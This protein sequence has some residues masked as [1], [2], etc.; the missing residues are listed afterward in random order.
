MP[1]FDYKMHGK[2]FTQNY[3]EMNL[4]VSLVLAFCS[5]R[6]YVIRLMSMFLFNLSKMINI[7]SYLTWKFYLSTV[8]LKNYPMSVQFPTAQFSTVK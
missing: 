4:I 2:N 7:W 1:Q 3:T 6:T 5:K 8:I